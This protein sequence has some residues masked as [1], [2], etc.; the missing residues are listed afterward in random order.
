[1]SMY[2][3][4]R[5]ILVERKPTRVVLDVGNIGFD[6][7]IP[8]STY[9]V[10]PTSGEV[11]L[12]IHV[13]QRDEGPRLFGFAS[14]AERALF[15]TLLG[16]P[17]VGPTAALQILSSA[18]IERFYEAVTHGD[19]AT[20]TRIKGIGKRTAQ[21]LI[22]ELAGKLPE[23]DQPPPA[24]GTTNVAVDACAAL[25]ALGVPVDRARAAVERAVGEL[26]APELTAGE[27]VRRALRYA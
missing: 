14:A 13:H 21:R 6:I 1:M 25:E 16:I 26:P 5:G 19:E 3:Y 27:L 7:A 22:V 15:R 11:R 8:V 24:D 12:L 9:S 10:L 4:L 23:I 17:R 18:T 20:L 2:E